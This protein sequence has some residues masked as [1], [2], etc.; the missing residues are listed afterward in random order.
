MLRIG[1]GP[2]QIVADAFVGR[3]D[4][5]RSWSASRLVHKHQPAVKSNDFLLQVPA[6]A[7]RFIYGS[8]G[9]GLAHQAL[10]LAAYNSAASHALS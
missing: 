9:Q 10:H 3:H 6:L 2:D 8:T 7:M 4:H 1:T 5:L